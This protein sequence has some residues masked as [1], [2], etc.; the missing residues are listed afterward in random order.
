MPDP[1]EGQQALLEA[2]F[3]CLAVD[4][5]GYCV[6]LAEFAVPTG[7]LPY[8]VLLGEFVDNLPEHPGGTCQRIIPGRRSA[9]R[10]LQSLA[11]YLPGVR[12]CH[13]ILFIVSVRCIRYLEDMKFGSLLSWPHPER[14]ALGGKRLTFL[15]CTGSVAFAFLPARR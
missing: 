5:A 2:F 10:P 11:V 7:H 12:F 6:R 13:R 14:I 15:A 8:K 4:G 1:E 9:W 3:I